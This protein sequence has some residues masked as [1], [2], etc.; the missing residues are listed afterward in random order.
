[1]TENSPSRVGRRDLA[2][3]VFA[4][5]LIAALIGGS[6]WIFR[7]F[8]LATIW[9]TMIVVATWPMMLWLQA[10]L[11]RRSLAVAVMTVAMLL[12]FLVP[13][14]MA[15]ETVTDNTETIAGWIRSLSGSAIPPPPDWV[16][17]FPLLGA[18]IAQRWIAIAAGGQEE[19]ATRVAPYVTNAAQW[20]AAAIGSVAILSIQFLLTLVIA[21][22]LYMRGEIA[23]DAL[24]RFC[25]RVAGERGEPAVRL[26]GE[27]IRAVALGVV[28]TALVQ[29]VLAWIG[30]AVVGVPFVG[31][32]TAVILLLCIAQIGPG[33]V[34]YPVAIW[35][36]WHDETAW[37]VAM[38][39]WALFA[40]T[41]DNFLRPILIRKGAHL[42]LLLIFVG[43]IGGL[44]A[45][46]VVGLFIGPVMLAISYTLLKDWVGEG[47]RA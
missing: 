27:A 36:F 6:V 17:T 33:L 21:A 22:I 10:R 9:A 39:V 46:G 47:K 34:L 18:R 19:L 38:L 16:R 8:L 31:L 23:S 37:G 4:L 5:L 43:V 25:D 2:R 1:M 41:M 28:V 42:P 44:I 40:G 13:L 14:L 30:L 7:P 3:T 11:R 12:T 26:A 45:F 24:I 20:V 15:I 29:T 35:L 32:F